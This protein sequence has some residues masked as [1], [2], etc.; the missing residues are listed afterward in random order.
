MSKQLTFPT[1]LAMS[2]VEVEVLSSD[3]DAK[4]AGSATITSRVL[5]V[6]RQPKL[7]K[8]IQTHTTTTTTN[9]K[10]SVL[11]H[12]IQF[13]HGVLTHN[14]QEITRVVR[15]MLK[16]SPAPAQATPKAAPAQ[17]RVSSSTQ[18]H[19]RS[20]MQR[21]SRDAQTNGNSTRQLIRMS[22]LCNAHLFVE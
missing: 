15:F 5:G 6:G 13:K 10:H 4:S 22:D 14:T 20:T 12:N 7:P 9:F 1:K 17:Q 16:P 11:T 3:T 2:V 21:S 8:Q 19:A 18:T